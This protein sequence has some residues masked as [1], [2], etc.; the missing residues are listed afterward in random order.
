MTVSKPATLEEIVSEAM[1][2]PAATPAPVTRTVTDPFAPLPAKVAE[3]TPDQRRTVRGEA[4]RGLEATG[5]RK[6]DAEA[7]A[8][9][10]MQSA[11]DRIRPARDAAVADDLARTQRSTRAD[12]IVAAIRQRG[13][14]A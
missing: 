13:V 2:R 10:H 9:L 7:A 6:Q 14:V 4:V 5:M 3:L 12:D 1:A 11:L 8:E